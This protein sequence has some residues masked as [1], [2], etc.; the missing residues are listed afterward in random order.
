MPCSLRLGGPCSAAACVLAS[1]ITC[2]GRVWEGASGCRVQGVGE[3]P[4][5]QRLGQPG[6][7]CSCCSS[8]RRGQQGRQQGWGASCGGG[9]GVS[10]RCAPAWPRVGAGCAQAAAPALDPAR[11]LAQ[12]AA[13]AARRRPAGRSPI[14]A[15][16]R[17]PAGRRPR[18]AAAPALTPP[19]APERRC[20]RCRGARPCAARPSGA[21]C[22]GGG[23]L[24]ALHKL[25]RASGRRRWASGGQPR[26]QPRGRSRAPGAPVAAAMRRLLMPPRLGQ[27]TRAAGRGHAAGELLSARAGR[28]PRSG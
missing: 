10:A 2:G 11:A 20:R 5:G 7:G 18:P 9:A 28:A 8:C 23:A 21:T 19:R 26:Q 12:A 27:P 1:V 22:D 4:Q 3:E 17:A 24:R 15:R 14:P 6:R 25:Q 13:A 16:R